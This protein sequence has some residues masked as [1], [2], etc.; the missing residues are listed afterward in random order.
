MTTSTT[1]CICTRDR[2]AALRATLESI[3]R[4]TD[5]V[6]EVIVSDDGSLAETQ[7]VARESGLHVRYV[8][9]P[10]LGLAA[11]RNHALSFLATDFVVFLDD[12]CHLSSDFLTEAHRCRRRSEERLGSQVVV[13]GLERQDGLIV[14]ASDQSFLGFQKKPYRDKVGLKSIVINSALFPSQL[15]KDVAFDPRLRYGYEEVEASTRIVAAGGTIVECDSAINDHL[16][17]ALGRDDYTFQATASRLY[18]T[19]KR[20][21]FTDHRPAVAFAF[22]LVAPIHAVL[23]GAKHGGPRGAWTA[24]RAIMVA[25]RYLRSLMH[26]RK[27]SA[28]S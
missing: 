11:N 16:P 17:S 28:R 26:E 13:S 12:D 21:A 25:A 5:P 7:Q 10:K 23:A 8:T 20:Y 6:D 18:A 2:P 19:F 9:G 22:L 24:I 4:S 1:V 15:I 14:R 3:A 27:V